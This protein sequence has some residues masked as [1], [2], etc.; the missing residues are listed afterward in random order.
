[1]KYDLLPLYEKTLKGLWKTAGDE[2]Q[3]KL[4][5]D[6]HI[7]CLC[8]KDSIIKVNIHKIKPYKNMLT[9]WYAHS[10]FVTAWKSAMDQIV[11][12]VNENIGNKKLL[13]MGY[14]NGASLSVLAHEY[15][16]FQNMNPLTFAFAP[17]RV[18]WLPFGNLRKRF[19]DL[20]VI[21]NRGDI[22]TH[23]LPNSFGYFHVGKKKMYGKFA[24][25]SHKLHYQDK[26]KEALK[27]KYIE[28]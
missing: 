6:E 5:G 27:D 8:L 26:Y 22:V 24:F 2:V 7:L 13:I 12:D 15:F 3:Y 14:G 28:I 18:I 9:T 20:F 10:G 19:K 11:Q 21:K 17:A 23:S 16:W 25:I 1:M 4:I